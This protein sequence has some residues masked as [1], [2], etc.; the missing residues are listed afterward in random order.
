MSA[1]FS[2]AAVVAYAQARMGVEAAHF[3]DL[4]GR[5]IDTQDGT[6]QTEPQR[7]TRLARA[8]AEGVNERA[9]TVAACYATWRAMRDLIA[10]V[11]S[12]TVTR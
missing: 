11:R 12:G 5:E 1:R 9:R 8:C 3:R 10:D 4:T 6:S 7:W 2:K